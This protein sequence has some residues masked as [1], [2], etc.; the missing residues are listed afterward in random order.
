[1]SPCREEDSDDDGD[2]ESAELAESVP[3]APAVAG[4]PKITVDALFGWR[5]PLSEEDQERIR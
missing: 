3:A 1:M 4:P 5:W 2:P